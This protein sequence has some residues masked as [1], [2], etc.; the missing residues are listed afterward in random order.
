MQLKAGYGRSRGELSIAPSE[1]A[2]ADAM[3]SIG[4]L[5]TPGANWKDDHCLQNVPTNS[6]FELPPLDAHRA[7]VAKVAV[8]E[9]AGTGIEGFSHGF[10]RPRS[11]ILRGPQR[12]SGLNAGETVR[13]NLLRAFDVHTLLRLP[14][15]LFYAQR[16][17]AKVQ[18]FDAK[19][20]RE[21]PCTERLWVYGQQ[22]NKRFTRKMKPLRRADPDEFVRCHRPGER[23]KRSQTWTP[24]NEGD[25]WRAF[26]YDELAKRHKLNLDL[27]WLR[28][29]ALEDGKNL[30]EQGVLAV[31]IVEHLH[32]ALEAFRV[33]AQD[34]DPAEAPC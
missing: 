15:G 14:T 9:A 33:I 25:P 21:K 32:A 23:R 11:R 20:A 7:R 16:V 22:T 28:N 10:C 8:G 19:P 26:E 34:L 17:R 29:S 12:C 1:R 24:E 6:Y 5:A 2:L 30:P 13:R 27:L 31:E 4:G 18:F 3:Q